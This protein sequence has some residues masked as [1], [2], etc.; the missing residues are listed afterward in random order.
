MLRPRAS[1]TPWSAALLVWAC[2]EAPTAP[3]VEPDGGLFDLALPWVNPQLLVEVDTSTVP[4]SGHPQ[5]VVYAEG[6]YPGW[7]P[8]SVPADMAWVILDERTVAWFDGSTAHARGEHRYQGNKGRVETTL[9]VL[10][11]GELLASR[12]AVREKDWL[13]WLDFGWIKH[14]DVVASIPVDRTCG[15]TAW[16]ASEHQAWWD[17]VGVPSL[18]TFGRSVSSSTSDLARQPECPPVP[19]TI[20]NGGSGGGSGG[21]DEEGYLTCYYWVTYDLMTGEIYD[22]EFLFCESWGG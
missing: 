21:Y 19:P 1:H 9:N 15:L 16:G 22:V 17:A 8:A 3:P 4:E 14:I 5:R 2:A 6:D 13:I 20:P 11:Q 18:R 10:H 12:T 7:D